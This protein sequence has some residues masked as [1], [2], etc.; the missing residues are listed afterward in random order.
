MNPSASG[1]VSKLGQLL[2]DNASRY[3]AFAPLYVD[4]KQTGFVYGVHVAPLSFVQSA[5]PLTEDEIAKVNHLAALYYAFVLQTKNESFEQFIETLFGF[6]M[7][8][9]LATSSQTKKIL[10]GKKNG[11]QL[12]KLIDSRIYLG[13]NVFNKAF[14][15]NLT[16][17]LLFID[18]LIYRAYLKEEKSLQG[19]AQLLE[20]V[21]INLAYHA[22]YSKEMGAHDLKLIKS[23][24]SSLSYVQIDPI[25][26]D[27]S[28]RELL[29]DNFTNWELEY[30]FDM[31]CLTVWED[32]NLETKESEFIYGIGK[33]LS[34]SEIQVAERLEEV[35]RFFAQNYA[36]VPYLK[37]KNLAYTFFEGLTKNVK[38]LLQR[39]ST[40]LRKELLESRELI[41]LLR[42][43]TQ[44]ELTSEEKKK[45][46]EQLLDIFKT[47]P[48]FAIF[49]L[50][51]GAVLL[52]IAI[53]L[54]PKLLP[55]AF[56]ENRLEDPPLPKTESKT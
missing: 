38:R 49:M 18:V 26:F 13:G 44:R 11:A 53:N 30:F 56:D 5:H 51:G 43:S 52:P 6:Y 1:W 33:D 12:E 3:E 28:Y 15:N 32:K 46:Q 29:K 19:H 4:L 14:G 42:Q 48:S 47:I 10:E 24:S 40:R 8:M 39:N 16:N 50:P 21:S 25:E 34:K 54:I 45:V 9:G 37:S 20:Y 31:A 55:S 41:D 17:A 36:K 27:G 2:A 23:L 22:L 7:E 35:Q